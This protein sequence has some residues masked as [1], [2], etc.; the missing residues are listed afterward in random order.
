MGDSEPDFVS[1]AGSEAGSD[2]DFES[3]PNFF[4]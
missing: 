1:E 4:P 2:S 3:S